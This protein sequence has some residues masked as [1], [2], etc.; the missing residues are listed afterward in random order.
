VIDGT[1]IEWHLI[2]EHYSERVA[3]R[4]GIR[5]IRHIVEG[6]AVL[7]AIGAPEVASR[8]FALH[9]LLQSDVNLTLHYAKVAARAPADSVLLAMEYRSVANAYLST[10]EISDVGEIRLSPLA[11][12]GQMLVADKVQNYKDFLAYHSSNH[13]RREALDSYF[14]LW[15][16]RLGVSPERLR[17]LMTVAG[18]AR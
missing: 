13:P 11:V 18:D 9:P 3:L 4:S 1:A 7:D 14:N 10:R 5:L 16:R 17:E 15:F 2:C 12:V 6:I 8:A